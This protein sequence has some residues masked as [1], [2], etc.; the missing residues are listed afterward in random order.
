MIYIYNDFGGT[1]TTAMAASYHLKKLSTDRPLTKDDILN[2][3]YFNKL[4]P[5]DCGKIIFHGADEDGNFVYTIGRKS[6]KIVVP[7][8]KNLSLLLQDKYNGDEPILFSNT[9]PSVPFVMKI[10]GF[11]SRQLKIDW[12]GVPLLVLGAKQCY[13]DI[14]RLVEH[15]KEI[16][17]ST[18]EKV[19]VL[20]NKQFK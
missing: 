17:Q 1:H 10:G 4:D 6:S 13:R 20:E 7:A 15:T 3:D 18:K 16:G 5:S 8:L 9:S 2:I 14:I 11:L 19:V 12:I